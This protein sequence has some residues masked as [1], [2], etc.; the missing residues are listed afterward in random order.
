MTF[1]RFGF[2]A[3]GGRRP[4]WLRH[5]YLLVVVVVGW[6][7]F[8]TETMSAGVQF[9]RALVGLQPGVAQLALPSLTSLQWLAFA[10]DVV[11]AVPLHPWLGRWVVT[12][13][14]MVTSA[15]MLAS[16]TAVFT[17]RTGAQVFGA[18]ARSVWRR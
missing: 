9:I 4:A 14:A 16:T 13:D 17:W 15:L 1:E 6:V 2:A 8:R 12:V 11:G 5:L 3:V 18:L 10:A 7:L